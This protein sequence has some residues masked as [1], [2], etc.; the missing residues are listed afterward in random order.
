MRKC[1][2]KWFLPTTTIVAWSYSLKNHMKKK[3]LT[4]TLVNAPT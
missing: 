4:F 2:V 1:K 3:E